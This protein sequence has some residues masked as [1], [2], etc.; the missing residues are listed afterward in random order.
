[1]SVLSIDTL[2]APETITNMAKALFKEERAKKRLDGWFLS[3][4]IAYEKAKACASMPAELRAAEELKAILENL[5]LSIST[6]AIFA[7][8]QS[9][10]FARSYALINPAFE[11]ET[12]SGYCDPTAVYGDIVPDGAITRERIAAVCE[13]AKQSDYV[14][15][16]AGVYDE[17]AAYTGEVAFFIEQVTGHLIPDFRPV[18]AHGVLPVIEEL[19]RRIASESRK[20]KQVNYMAMKTTLEA[21]L[22]L[23]ERYAA[24]AAAQKAE[25]S[26]E[27]PPRWS[28][29]NR[30]CARFQHTGRTIFMKPFSPSCFYGKSCV[31]SRRPTPSLFR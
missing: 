10:A 18:L 5:P 17:Y 8:T 30:R 26:A 19:D 3:R 2:Y 12:F 4:E 21:L 28:C 24:I 14:K 1:M 20:K 11:V 7:G 23:A 16:L 15:K 6:H 31:S 22:T 25:A 9:D 27:R 29:L 13:T